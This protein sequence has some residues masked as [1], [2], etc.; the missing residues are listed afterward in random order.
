MKNGKIVVLQVLGG[1][2]LGGAESRVMDLTRRLGDTDIEYAFLLHT[3]GGDFYEKEAKSLACDIYRLPRFKFFNI[4]SYK[5]AVDEFFR[6]HPEIDIV[7]G[8]MT[9]TASIYLP[10]ARKY[11][12]ITIAHARSAGVDKGIKGVL[13]N[14]LRRHLPRKT[15]YMWSCSTEAAISVYGQANYDAGRVYVLPNAIDTERFKSSSCD[16]DVIN[17]YKTK[18]GLNDAFVV[19]HV[20]SFR[21]AKNHDFLLDIFSE[22]IKLKPNAKLLLVGDGELVDTIKQ[23][24]EMLGLTDKVIFAGNHGDVNNFY[25]LMDVVLFPSHYEGLPGT[26]VESQAAGVRAL[27]SSN[28]TRDVG[29]TNLV[30]YKDLSD[31]AMSFAKELMDYCSAKV[32]SPD[33]SIDILKYKGFDVDGQVTLLEAK[34]KNMISTDK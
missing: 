10:I 31:G 19:G 12:K 21:Y 24:S 5:K 27:I 18:Y 16:R 20:G 29:V 13:T 2:N 11:N 30:R 4:F 28:I 34:Y 3:K 25:Q 6:Q 17:G 15:D 26:I 9:S 8:H 22:F 14:M 23:K 1:L 32:V 33:E 7:Q